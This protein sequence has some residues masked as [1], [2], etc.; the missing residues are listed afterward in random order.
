MKKIILLFTSISIF[1]LSAFHQKSDIIASLPKEKLSDYGFFEGNGS[2]QKPAL[3]VYTYSLN[4]P[5]FT[6][7]AEKLRFVKLPNNQTVP[8]NDR[9][10]LEFPV[11]SVIIKT[12]Y[13]PNDF[14]KPE[15]GRK[16]IE[17]RLLLHEEDGWKALDYVW[18]DE[19][20][21]AFLEVAGD[22]KE[23]SYIDAQGKKKKHEY[24]IPNINQCKGCHNRNEKMSPIG[25]SARQLNGEYSAWNIPKATGV[26]Q[27]QLL[28]WQKLGILTN[29]PA[30]EQVPKAAVW[31]KPESG[32]IE[33]RARIWLDI[34]CAHCH[35]MGGPAQTSGL[36][37][38]IYETDPIAY[39]ILKTPV[40]AGRGS[41]NKK[42][43][44]VP[45]KPDESIIVY[46]MESNDPGVMMPEVGRKTT[47]KEGVELIKEWIRSMK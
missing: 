19:Q 46:R 24:G 35:R 17:T 11:G 37:L 30:I 43:D 45:G 14:R 33:E 26:P 42:Y 40:A 41:G 9:E 39:G 38:S 15:L 10:V 8:Y 47:H 27:N 34:N 32:S 28:H 18:N 20:T 16:L 22:V 44:I 7:Y 13:Y 12:F 3:G 1:A 29:L 2:E 5:L 21:E 23:V 6:D 25:P 36:N 31:N 4:T